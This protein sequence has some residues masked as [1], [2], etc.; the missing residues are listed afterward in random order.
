MPKWN[1]SLEKVEVLP[2]IDGKEATR[3]T[4]KGNMQM[5]IVTERKHAAEP[6]RA[7]DGRYRRAICRLLDLRHQAGRQ[8]AAKLL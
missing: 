6:P 7:L 2:P 4:F 3:Q 8:T 1:R 5:T